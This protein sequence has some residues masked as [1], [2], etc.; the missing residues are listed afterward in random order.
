MSHKVYICMVVCI[1]DM[2]LCCIAVMYVFIFVLASVRVWCE[3]FFANMY[4]HVYVCVVMR[5]CIH[6]RG[7]VRVG[8]WRRWGRERKRYAYIPSRLP[9]Y[10]GRSGPL[11]T[12]RTYRACAL[13]YCLRVGK[14]ALPQAGIPGWRKGTGQPGWEALHRL[15]SCRIRSYG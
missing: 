6:K 5:A 7:L 14:D 10:G 8:D 13:T 9:P 2:K 15:A 1:N 3:F 4:L 12:A 11:P